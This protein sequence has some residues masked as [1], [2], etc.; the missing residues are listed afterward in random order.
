MAAHII[1]V[2]H[3]TVQVYNTVAK[4]WRLDSDGLVCDLI[5]FNL[6]PFLTKT[7]SRSEVIEC[8]VDEPEDGS[9]FISLASKR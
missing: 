8:F 1:N 5:F 3:H 7:D 4:A 2:H 6:N 9:I